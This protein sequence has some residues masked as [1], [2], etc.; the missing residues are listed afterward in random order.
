[1]E[2]VVTDGT[3]KR[4]QLP[5]Y[6]IA[7]KTGTAQKLIDGRY[8]HSDHNASFIGFMPSRAPELAI[9]VVIDSAK[10]PNGD[11]GGTVAAPIFRRIAESALHYLGIGPTINAPAPVLVARHDAPDT[12]PA[13]H[14]PATQP[15]VS[16]V[17]DGPPGTL[18]DLRGMSAREAIRKLAKLGMTARASGDGF[19]VSQDPAP[20]TPIDVDSVCRLVLQ[21]WPLPP[22][23]ASQ[24]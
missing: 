8:S 15:V 20:G 11:H 4:A 9:V 23:T 10:G 14:Q 21:R 3:A 17:A 1:M 18:P 16:L 7:G 13:S 2:G 22:P 5:G 24:P 12:T 6:T 19:V